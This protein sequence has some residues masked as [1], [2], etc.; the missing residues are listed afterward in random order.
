MKTTCLLLASF[1]AAL[2]SVVCAD[3]A[4]FTPG[5]LAV[6]RLGDGAT[7]LGATG[8]VVFIDEYTPA[9][10]LTQSFVIPATG[11]PLLT[12]SGSATSE[13][14]LMRSPNGA[15]LAFAGY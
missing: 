14:A 2:F 13:G 1:L 9:G 10:S 4:P 5:N 7:A 12:L 8:T 3:A 15:L 6:V 11:S